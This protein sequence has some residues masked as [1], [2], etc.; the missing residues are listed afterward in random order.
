ME[1]SVVESSWGSFAPVYCH[2]SWICYHGFDDIPVLEG[3]CLSVPKAC[4][5]LRKLAL[6]ISAK[7][8]LKETNIFASL[9]GKKAQWINSLPMIFAS[10]KFQTLTKAYPNLCSLFLPR[11]GWT[12][13]P[14]LRCYKVGEWVG[15][16]KVGWHV[17]EFKPMKR[18]WKWYVQKQLPVMILSLLCSPVDWRRFWGFKRG[19]SHKM[20]GVWAPAWLH[21]PCL[22]KSWCKEETNHHHI[23][24][25]RFLRCC[26]SS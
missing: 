17:S 16:V 22:T 6:L 26:Y 8:D 19:Q 15:G 1:A 12:T 9:W 18:E 3:T 14:S 13:F 21:G 5:A 7:K 20:E 11:H 4:Q 2:F 10:G 24:P 23:M 25:L